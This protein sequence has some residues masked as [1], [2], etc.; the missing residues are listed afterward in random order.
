MAAND[1]CK[2]AMSHRGTIRAHDADDEHMLELL[3]CPP[4][5]VTGIFATSLYSTTFL[6]TW[7]TVQTLL[8]K[9]QLVDQDVTGAHVMPNDARRA[10]CCTSRIHARLNMEY[11]S[12]NV[13]KYTKNISQRSQSVNNWS[14]QR[15]SMEERANRA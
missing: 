3:Q 11:S 2:F 8:P 13:I 4:Q 9:T 10:R 7:D 12:T 1:S 14:S 6:C 15:Q 5:N